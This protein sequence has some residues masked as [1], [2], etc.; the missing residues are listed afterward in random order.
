MASF[1]RVDDSINM[2]RGDGIIRW[3]PSR[4]RDEFITANITYCT[5]SL[6]K[7]VG[8]VLPEN[9]EYKKVAQHSKFVAPTAYDWAPSVPGH[10]LPGLVAVGTKLGEVH[11]LRVDDDSD[12][13][14][15][16][17]CKVVRPCHAVA[18]NTQ[19][20]L[21]VGL[22]RIRNDACLQIWDI[23]QRLSHWDPTKRGLQDRSPAAEP[24]MR[25]EPSVAVSACRWF[26]D[27][28]QTLVIGIK[29]NSMKIHDLRGAS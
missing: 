17:P 12:D 29:N 22:D 19:G 7:V 4:S 16:L 24:Y 8:K 3:S 18:F 9:V 21:A 23:N 10:D 2:D 28:P 11:L 15:T 25:M 13:S 6:N 5:L 1:L 14:I 20:L 26:E 27:Q